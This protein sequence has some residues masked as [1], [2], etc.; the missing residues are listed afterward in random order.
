MR[1]YI[2]SLRGHD[3]HGTKTKEELITLLESIDWSNV[4][5]L[6]F[7]PVSSLQNTVNNFIT[8]LNNR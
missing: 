7:C 3:I 8:E 5:E 6:E 2:G 1:G 4:E